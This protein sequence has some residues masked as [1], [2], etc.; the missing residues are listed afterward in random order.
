MMLRSMLN[1]LKGYTF[2]ELLFVIIILGLI[3]SNFSFF[4]TF[5]LK[6]QVEQVANDIQFA[7]SMGRSQSLLGY[8][9][10]LIPLIKDNWS[11]GIKLVRMKDNK[12]LEMY[13]WD[14]QKRHVFCLLVWIFF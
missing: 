5:Y 8:E 6:K 3:I 9:I 2:I 12:R 10:S 4:V 14:W 11:S 7:V 1:K 13:Q